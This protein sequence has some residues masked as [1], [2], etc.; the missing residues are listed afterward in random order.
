MSDLFVYSFRLGRLI[1]S[2]V[3]TVHSKQHADVFERET[4]ETTNST[5]THGAVSQETFLLLDFEKAI[6]DSVLD[7]KPFDRDWTA[8]P[9]PVG[10]ING[11]VFGG[12]I[13]LMLALTK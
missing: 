3:F 7:D 8:L 2:L 13:P 11:L 4:A 5:F 1:F 6:L 9:N 10:S 12:W